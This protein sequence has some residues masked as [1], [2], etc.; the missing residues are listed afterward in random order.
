MRV[1]RIGSRV[2]PSGAVGLRSARRMG[3]GCRARPCLVGGTRGTQDAVANGDTRTLERSTTPHQGERSPSPSGATASTIRRGLE[4]LNWMLRDWRRD[5]PT[6]MDPRLFD[7]LWEV[8]REVGLR[9][10][11]ST[12]TPPTGRPQ[13][14]AMLRR[15]SARSPRTAS[16]CAARPW[17]STCPTCRS[18]ASGR[19]RMRLQHGGVGYY[20]SAYTPFIH[21]DVGSVR[22]W[23]RMTRD[24]L[25]R[26]F[27]DGKTVHIPTD[28]EPA[29]RIRAGEGGSH[30]RGLVRCRLQRRRVG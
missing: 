2:R 20:P 13:T 7:T 3:A 11:R 25:V 28:G 15:R 26:L 12:S 14:N 8:Y 24:Q 1:L 9:A 19:S 30:R 27:P 22:A 4:Q 5:E 18:T 29:A 6:E 21:L 23:P 16:T 17:I 10:S